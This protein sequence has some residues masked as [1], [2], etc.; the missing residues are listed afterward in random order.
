M[1]ICDYEQPLRDRLLRIIPRWRRR[2]H[3][4]CHSMA[5]I[6]VK[7]FFCWR[8]GNTGNI[9]LHLARNIVALQVEKRCCTYY[10]PPQTLSR[11]KISFLQVEA[12]C[13]SKLNRRLLF[14]TNF[15]NL[16]QQILLSD[17][18]WGGWYYVQQRFSMLRCK[19]QRFVARITSPLKKVINFCLTK[20][21][22]WRQYIR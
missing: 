3:V 9:F 13:C 14:S 16:Q 17:I 11:N 15:F 5:P 10:H 2:S 6:S 7:N 21:N 20:G 1:K 4:R 12:A 22:L 19:L 8:P 18:V